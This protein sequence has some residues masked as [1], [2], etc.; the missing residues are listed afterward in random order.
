MVC[1]LLCCFLGGG[2]RR[3]AALHL[4]V[5]VKLGKYFQSRSKFYFQQCGL[6]AVMCFGKCAV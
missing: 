6:S 5:F 3:R 1:R 4:V 2:G